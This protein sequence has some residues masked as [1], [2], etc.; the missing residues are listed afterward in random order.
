MSTDAE[1]QVTDVIWGQQE[2]ELVTAHGYSRNHLSLW[3]YPS[4]VK[5]ADFEGH[6]SRIVGLAQSP[7]GSLVCSAAADET[8]RFWKMFSPVTEKSSKIELSKMNPILRTI[9]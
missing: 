4:L 1:S 9:R 8:L 3:K 2:R 6:E 5:A 7:D